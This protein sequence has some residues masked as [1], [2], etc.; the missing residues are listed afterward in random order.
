M[1]I[2]KV[3]PEQEAKMSE[4]ADKWMKIGLA[5]SSLPFPDKAVIMEH[6]SRLASS[7]WLYN[8]G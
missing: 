4:N 7:W 5:T 1:D 2:L 8:G 3:L 6:M